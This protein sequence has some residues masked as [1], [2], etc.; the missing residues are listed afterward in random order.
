MPKPD[1]QYSGVPTVSP[2]AGNTLPQLNVHA[3]PNDF[4]AQV[5]QAE[6]KL[7][8]TGQHVAEE[9]GQIE[10]QKQG[11]INETLATNAET[12]HITNLGEIQSKYKSTEGLA[13]APGSD[14]YN[15]AINDATNSRQAIRDSLPN[16][17]AQRSFDML[18]RRH[19]SNAILDINNYA[20]GQIKQ[21]NLKSFQDGTSVA[22]SR[23][24]DPDVAAND[25]RFNEIQADVNHFLAGQLQL[26]GWPVKDSSGPSGAPTFT[27]DVNGQRAKIVYNQLYDASMGA[28]WENRIRSLAENPQ[29]GNVQA[30][31]QVFKQ[32][33]DNIPSSTYQKI[34]AY[35]TPKLRDIADTT[36][37]SDAVLQADQG[38]HGAVTGTAQSTSSAPPANVGNVK[39]ADGTW[40]Q[41]ATPSDGA[42]LVVKTLQSDRYAGKT[43]AEIG[44]I[45]S[46]GDSNW[47]KNVSA[48]SG[49]PLDSKPDL[50]NPQVLGTLVRGIN[51]AEKG[52]SDLASQAD[53]DTGIQAALGGKEIATGTTASTAPKQAVSQADYYRTNYE[54]IVEQ[55]RQTAMKAH[56]DDPLFVQTA[57]AR[58]EQHL[59]RAITDQERAY[60]VDADAV[61]T[62]LFGQN[63]PKTVD[64]LEAISPDVKAAWQR[65]QVN[66]PFKAQA[67]ENVL[68]HN[69]RGADKDQA[70]YGDK[71]YDVIQGIANHSIKDVSELNAMLGKGL[72][73]AGVTHGTQLL[74]GK[75]DVDAETRTRQESAAL[76]VAKDQLSFED[77]T[78]FIK[79]PE[80]M[81]RFNGYFVP[82]FVKALKGARA[83]GVPDEESLSLASPKNII[84]PLVD[85]YKR[86]S[87]DDLAAR[88]QAGAEVPAGEVPSKSAP[89]GMDPR[90]YAIAMD[91]HNGKITKAEG[92]KK[93]LE[94]G[95]ISAPAPVEAGAPISR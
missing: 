69:A 24:S 62:A 88:I 61:Q 45:W 90:L 21:A 67:I 89:A 11:M 4:G 44:P 72:T 52:K 66:E 58:V 31:Y 20:A 63:K 68:T 55:A 3:T 81:T 87:S 49:I 77:E 95:L 53:I 30:A 51:V 59:G 80:G 43:L 86:S 94:A 7:G 76:A 56:P 37:A 12:Q 82:A 40:A 18:A 8:Q 22:V 9:Q 15:Q 27:D 26:Q 92:Q 10:L 70:N 75:G 74:Q 28:A 33:K 35:F 34:D 42:A 23:A 85:M 47:A 64:E 16:P 36:I 60:K 2:E 91:V 39:R 78:H 46:N 71:I 1:V 93:A 14:A 19:E 25:G 17:A 41:P 29:S 65:L 73:V 84:K 5:G 57:V 50:T 38:Y 6:E 83:A 54:Q 48:A 79:D 13:A 32:N